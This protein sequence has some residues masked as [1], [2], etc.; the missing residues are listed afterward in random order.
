MVILGSN[1]DSFYMFLKRYPLE[2]KNASKNLFSVLVP[3]L[4]LLIILGQVQKTG[5]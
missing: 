2:A 5:Y 1:R 4:K 3:K